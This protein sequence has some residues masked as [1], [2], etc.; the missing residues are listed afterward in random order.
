MNASL[1]RVV[2]SSPRLQFSACWNKRP[3]KISTDLPF[4]YL[5]E[6]KT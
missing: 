6:K 1:I 5:E 2:S 3:K 4:C